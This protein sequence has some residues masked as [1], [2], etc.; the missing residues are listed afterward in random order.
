MSHTLQATNDEDDVVDDRPLLTFINI[1]A[2]F[3]L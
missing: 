3:I 1:Y 2:I